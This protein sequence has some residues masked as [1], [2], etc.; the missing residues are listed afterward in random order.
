MPRSVDHLVKDI[1]TEIAF[2]KRVTKQHTLKSYA[3]DDLTSRAV[4]RA[5]LT[6]SEA[7]RGLPDDELRK[8]PEISWVAI[9]AMGNII[10]HEY[11]KIADEVIWDT[12]Q[13]N[14]GPLERAIKQI[15]AS[16]RR[17]TSGR[18]PRS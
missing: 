8:Q 17:N 2:V 1:L 16:R 9:K 7:V 18:R 14:L 5:L 12:V 11:H 6:I 13:Q 15:R 4:E 10:R 3:A